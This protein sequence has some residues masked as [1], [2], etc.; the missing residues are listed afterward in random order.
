VNRIRRIYV[1]PIYFLIAVLCLLAACNPYAP[2]TTVIV[3]VP[4]PTER[5]TAIPSRTPTSIPPTPTDIPIP[6]TETP[7]RCTETEGQIVDLEF[8]STIVGRPMSYRAYLPPCYSDTGRRYPYAILMHGSDQ[9]QTE[10][11]DLLGADEALERGMSLGALPPMILIFPDGGGANG[12]ANINVFREGFSWESYILDELMPQ[13]ETNF[14]TWNTREGRAIGGISRGGFWAY[15]IG[16]RHPGVF[17]AIGG[18]SAFFDS[19]N[20][21]PTHNPLDLARTVTFPLGEQPRLW[22]DVG[23]DDYAR[24]GIERFVNAL[25]ER[26]IDPG[27]TL[28][29]EGRHEIS[30]WR[31]HVSEYLSFYGLTWS[32]ELRDLPSCSE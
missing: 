26:G 24:D 27:F 19:D 12:L 9:D 7:W 30:Y 11:T 21:P 14:C 18:H 1:R 20:A 2:E 13:I 29:P 6:P 31:D 15:L 4:S 8:D 23:R 28:H 16:L 10:W 25:S 22:M 3:V 32:R 17:G 5:P